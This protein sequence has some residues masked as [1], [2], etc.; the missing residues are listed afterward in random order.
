MLQQAQ[1]GQERSKRGYTL[2]EITAAIAI[3]AMI[4]LIVMEGVKT[5]INK[6]KL[7]HTVNEMMSLA[8][9]SLDF[10]NS[11]GNWPVNPINLTPTYM[12]TAVS[13]SPFG[14]NYQISSLKNAVTVSTTVPSG[15]AQSYKQGTLLEISSGVSHDTIAVTQ[16]LPNEFSGRMEYDKKYTYQ[17]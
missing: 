17:Q 16:R 15:L 2:I 5:R 9:A 13:S 11:Q 6:A 4:F 8:Q 10:Y 3:M 14:E 7:E 12:Y 1:L